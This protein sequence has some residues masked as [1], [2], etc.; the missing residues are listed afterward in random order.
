MGE[1]ERHVRTVKQVS[2]LHG[3]GA[4]ASCLA[5]TR[6]LVSHQGVHGT[7]VGGA[8]G[9]TAWLDGSSNAAHHKA[10]APLGKVIEAAE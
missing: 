6:S 8:T 9:S 4:D 5:S 3:T 10:E 1:A 7:S 2:V